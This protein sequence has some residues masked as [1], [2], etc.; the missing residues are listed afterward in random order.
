M[1]SFN[2][3]E[4]VIFP[5]PFA[6]SSLYPF[7]YDESTMNNETLLAS[8][9][10]RFLRSEMGIQSSAAHAE[11][12]GDVLTVTLTEALTPIGQVAALTDGGDDLLETAY[13]TLYSMHQSQLHTLVAQAVG[14]SVRSSEMSVDTKNSSFKIIF[15]F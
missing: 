4:I 15:G 5:S 7:G 10:S 2:L 9:V 1:L 8:I 13:D 12:M 6:P 11:W 14:Q 3:Y